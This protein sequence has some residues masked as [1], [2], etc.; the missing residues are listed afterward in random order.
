MDSWSSSSMTST[1][2]LW[3]ARNAG[4]IPPAPPPTAD[5]EATN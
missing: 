3:S 2:S 1:R 5:V 4:S